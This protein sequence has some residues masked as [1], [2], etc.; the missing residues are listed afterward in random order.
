[1]N[2][3]R[4]ARRLLGIE[5]SAIKQDLIRLQFMLRDYQALKFSVKQEGYRLGRE[6]YGQI[7]QSEVP[8]ETNSN[9]ILDC[10]PST[11][12]DIESP[13]F[14]FWCDKLKIA[15][16]PHR[17]L[18]EYAYILQN[19][20]ALGKI[21]PG[22]KAMGFGCGSEP[23]PSFLAS[24]GVEVTVTDLDP[25]KVA[26]M[27]WAETG[28]HLSSLESAY[29][30]DLVQRKDFVDLVSL[31]YVDM[32]AIPSD[33]HGQYDFC[34]SVCALEHLG[35][36]KAGMDFIRNSLDCLRA[37]GVAIH[38]TEF[39]YSHVSKTVDNWQT[40]LF[41]RQ[42]FEELAKSL[43]QEG[44]EVFPLDFDVGS[45]PLDCFVDLPPY[46]WDE[47]SGEDVRLGFGATEEYRPGHLKLSVDGFPSTCFGLTIV[48]TQ[49]DTAS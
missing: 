6:L 31:R 12:T 41:L 49:L 42:H 19:A 22:K 34:W 9:L 2:L 47:A 28:Q 10:K 48:K 15:P 18:W 13:W 39:N 29:V 21:Q 32:N 45:Q 23:L 5:N 24:Y 40:V 16:L 38:T 43:R 20:Y 17:K 3:A 36:I 1:M 14:R 35:S 8:S 7:L 46:S 33:T 26:G 11:Q 30:P 27:G 4:K 25:D 44:F 37:G